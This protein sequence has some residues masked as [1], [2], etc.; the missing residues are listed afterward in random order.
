MNNFRNSVVV[1]SAILLSLSGCKPKVKYPA[2]T[3]TSGTIT[4][5]ADETFQPILDAELAVF[6]SLYTRAKVQVNYTTE[7]DALND[8]FRDS[9]QII[10]GTREL[11]QEEMEYFRTK[12]LV[13]VS[14]KIAIDAV[15]LIVNPGNKDT[16]ITVTDFA[17]VLTGEIT[18]WDQLS[19]NAANEPVEVVFDNKNS[20][21]VRYMLD[22]LC[23]G[24]KISDYHRAL[25]KNADVIEYVSTHPNAIGVIGVSWISDRDDPKMLSFLD[26]IKVMGISRGSK[27][28][29]SDSYQPYQAFMWNGNYPFTRNIYVIVSEPRKG[30]AT[31]LASFLASE[32][33]QRIILKSGILPATQPYRIIEVKDNL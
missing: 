13:P 12:K 8:L 15:A 10:I 22:S 20:S 33:G 9:V 26:K 7:T 19:N 25:N 5:T 17:K 18:H 3:P 30:L 31:G 23:L 24:K 29:P 6:Q 1:L 14:L 32:R 4:I 11:S 2:D 28:T 27:A 21:T 16:L